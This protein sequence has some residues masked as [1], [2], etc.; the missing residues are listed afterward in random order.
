MK[1]L[2]RDCQDGNCSSC[3][4]ARCAWCR[5][6]TRYT[7]SHTIQGKVFCGPSDSSPCAWLY[8]QHYAE[9]A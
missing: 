8:R 9:A 4:A 7:Q 1:C 5:K 6:D 3:V 2:I